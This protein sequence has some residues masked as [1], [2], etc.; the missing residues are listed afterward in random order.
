MKS[1]SIDVDQINRVI[2]SAIADE[3]ARSFNRFFDFL[4]IASWTGETALGEGGLDMDDAERAACWK[5]CAAF[6]GSDDTVTMPS[7]ASIIGDWG[8]ALL[9]TV[10]AK[11][12]SFQFKAAARE[13]D[14]ENTFRNADE[15]YQHAAAAAN[16]LNGRRRLISFVA[17]HSLIGFILAVLTPNLQRIDSIDARGQTPEALQSLLA[18]GD[19][20]IAT[21]TLWRYLMQEKVQAPDNAMAVTFGEAMTPELATDMR[22]AGFSVLRELYGS[23]ET[24][25]VGWRDSASDAFTLFD[26]WQQDGDDIRLLVHQ[27]SAPPAVRLMDYF[28]WIDERRFRLSGRRDGAV[29]IGAVNVLPIDVARRLSEHSMIKLCDVRVGE[30]RDGV[31]SL[32]AHIVLRDEQLPTDAVAREIDAW[33]REHLRHYE[34]PRIY[35]FEAE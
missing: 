24:G 11:L 26:H 14:I 10:C 2:G 27:D 1:F 8:D 17:P 21:P 34:R 19:V 18:Y 9:A 6:F 4:A 12:T 23:T 5:R 3:L 13:D 22:H 28:D 20:V 32:I 29:Q 16:L 15:V 25:L 7:G 31:N 30:R 33:C 35:R